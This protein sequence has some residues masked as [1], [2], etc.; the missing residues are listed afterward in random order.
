[1][2]EWTLEIETKK[3][4]KKVKNPRKVIRKNFILFYSIKVLDD[5]GKW[6]HIANTDI[7]PYWRAPEAKE[8]IEK[9]IKKKQS[10][11]KVNI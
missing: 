1:M 11:V 2:E 7:N 6:H 5:D 4:I 8:K 3:T 9:A 10:Y